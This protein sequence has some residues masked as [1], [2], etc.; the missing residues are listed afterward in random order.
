MSA[1]ARNVV[2]DVLESKNEEAEKLRKLSD[3]QML[4]IEDLRQEVQSLRRS[5]EMPADTIEI[6]RGRDPLV[7]SLIENVRE[8]EKLKVDMAQSLREHKA[9]VSNLKSRNQGLEKENAMLLEALRRGKEKWDV[10]S[11]KLVEKR[12]AKVMAVKEPTRENGTYLPGLYF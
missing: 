5:K 9:V 2:F 4:T 1:E 10:F 3:S 7:H 11:K 8:N 12:T 6:Q